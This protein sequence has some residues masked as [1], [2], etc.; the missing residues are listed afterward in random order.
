MQMG[1]DALG[2]GIDISKRRA[3]VCLNHFS[4]TIET[5]IV[6]NDENGI[7]TIRRSWCRGPDWLLP[8]TN[9]A[10]FVAGSL[11]VISCE[12]LL[13]PFAMY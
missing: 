5:F 13:K 3:D 7:S 4:I 12:P 6:S 11:L 2:L 10:M 1:D 8:C 9:P